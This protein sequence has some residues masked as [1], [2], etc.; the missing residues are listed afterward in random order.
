M[1]LRAPGTSDDNPA[2]GA[3]CCAD[4]SCQGQAQRQG[5]ETPLLTQSFCNIP[6]TNYLVSVHLSLIVLKA[7]VTFDVLESGTRQVHESGSSG[8]AVLLCPGTWPRSALA[9]GPRPP[10]WPFCWK[11][12]G[13]ALTAPAPAWAPPFPSGS[14][15]SLYSVMLQR[16]TSQRVTPTACA[17]GG[18]GG[19][20]W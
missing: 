4:H 10:K 17:R 19:P 5:S 8:G 14:R 1:K 20:G 6:D 18:W 2:A 12:C 7:P 15:P 13:W 16:G 11:R 9:P 3:L